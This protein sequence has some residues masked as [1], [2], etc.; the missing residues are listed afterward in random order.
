MTMELKGQRVLLVYGLL[1]EVAASLHRLGL[2]YMQCEEEWLR[3]EGAEPSIVSLPTAAPVASNATRLAATLLADSRPT[4]IIA[5][6]KGGLETLAALSNAEARARCCGF[7]AL[8]SPFMGS[9]VADAVV[10]AKPLA[11]ASIGLA[12]MLRIGSGEG[13]RD[14][15]THARQAWMAGHARAVAETLKRVPTVCVATAITANARGRERL[16]LA[17]G[18]WLE[19]Q[20]AGPNDG[21]VPVSSALLPGARHLVA[22]GSHIAGVSRGGGRDPIGLVT[23]ALSLLDQPPTPPGKPARATD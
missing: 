11:A 17:A 22:E 2:E 21:L 7:I 9:P 13:L 12:R 16:H 4:L 1:G 19:K 5:H 10:A 18:R 14:L 8:Q 20:G 23:R 3:Q 15:T 6:S